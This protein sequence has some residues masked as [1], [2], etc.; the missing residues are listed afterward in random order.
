MSLPEPREPRD[1][2]RWPTIKYAI[3]SNARTIRLCAIWIV[4]IA[5][6]VA[7]TMIT[8]LMRHVL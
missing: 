6:P 7:A 4:M 8:L 1:S 2:G 3:D 5:A